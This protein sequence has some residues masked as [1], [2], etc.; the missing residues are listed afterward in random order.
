MGRRVTV[1]YRSPRCVSGFFVR[2]GPP[3]ATFSPCLSCHPQ[4]VVAVEYH[5]Q[6]VCG[7]PARRRFRVGPIDRRLRCT[8]LPPDQRWLPCNVTAVIR[9]TRVASGGGPAN[10]PW[11]RKRPRGRCCRLPPAASRT[12]SGLRPA[13]PHLGLTPALRCG[14]GGVPCSPGSHATPPTHPPWGPPVSATLRRPDRH[15]S[16][17]RY[18]CRHAACWALTATPRK[19]DP[20]HDPYSSAAVQGVRPPA[21]AT[22]RRVAP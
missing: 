5:R 9:P 21:T 7:A 8:A 1:V 16:C 20:L 18:G 14:P 4:T 15:A 19:A 6:A 22:A 11:P 2:G 12:A 17:R 13:G 3:G 10:C